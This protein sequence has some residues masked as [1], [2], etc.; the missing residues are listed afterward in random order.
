MEILEFGD[1]SKRKIILI[2]GFQSPYQ[3]WDKYIKHYENKFHIIVPILPGH[4]PEQIENNFY[5]GTAMNEML[6]KKSA[7][8]LA[9][10]Y[11]NVKVKCFK[12]R[13]HCEPALLYPDMMI[14]ELEKV[15]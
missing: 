9:R 2:H 8:Y 13:R 10:H 11:S 7:K 14:E 6:A 5:H 3:V 12:G 1:K 4:N 15:L